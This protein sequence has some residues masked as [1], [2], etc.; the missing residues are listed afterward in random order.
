MRCLAGLRKHGWSAHAR[1]NWTLPGALPGSPRDTVDENI[2]KNWRRRSG[3]LACRSEYAVPHHCYSHEMGGLVVC[4]LSADEADECPAARR[5]PG[6][7]SLADSVAK[8]FL[9]H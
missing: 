8:V 5:C 2:S 1:C 3:S 4:L 7:P 6:C 9:R